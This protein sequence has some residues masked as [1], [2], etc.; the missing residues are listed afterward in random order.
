M[1]YKLFK[2]PVILLSAIVTLILTG[3]NKNDTEQ[4][5]AGSAS[6]SISVFETGND[7]ESRAVFKPTEN[8][9]S[10]IYAIGLKDDIE[11][12]KNLTLESISQI[13]GNKETEFIFKDIDSENQ[14]YIFAMAYDENKKPGPVSVQIAK[15]ID[16]D[17]KVSTQYISDESAGFTIDF[18]N[19]Y[20]Y[21]DWALG[22]PE[23][24]EKFLNGE[25]ETESITDPI[26][27]HKGINYFNLT[28]D[29]EYSFFVKGYDRIGIC[30]SFREIQ[31]TTASKDNC[32]KASLN[33]DEQD[34][35]RGK[36]TFTA[37][38]NCG[39]ICVLMCEKGYYDM[40]MFDNSHFSGNI[41]QMLIQWEEINLGE[42]DFTTKKSLTKVFHT[43]SLT[44]ESEL[45]AYVL[46]YDKDFNPAGLQHFT[47]TTPAFNNEAP[48]CTVSISIS[49][50]TSSGAKY[51]YRFGEN[52]L[53]FMYDTVEADW[54]DDVKNNSSE[55]NEF[56][57]HNIL[58]ENQQYWAYSKD[59][60]NGI[61]EFTESSGN[62]NFRY[63]AAAC[64]MN[65]NGIKGW[66][67]A[68]LVEY[69]TLNN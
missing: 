48:D 10:F 4:I 43:A 26:L 16:S 34:V 67:P 35:Y 17:F 64:P 60:E 3:C 65:E 52:T 40:I 41:V 51:T 53:G 5:D 24:K 18:N 20:S 23:D 56:Y 12:F 46:S 33:I 19:G 29:T 36:Y 31:F 25:L 11:S 22:R 6:V 55:W 50:I 66:Q 58:F 45:E 57:L 39:K 9:F 69:T 21:C 30:T 27:P 47:F 1:N 54:Y 13:E 7:S 14:Y 59:Y 62:P 37:N 63:Y 2:I 49:D 44:P 32:P 42:V 15:T 38:D 8:T 28:P 61:V 68:V